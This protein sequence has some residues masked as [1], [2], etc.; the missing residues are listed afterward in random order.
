MPSLELLLRFARKFLNSSR[1]EERNAVLSFSNHFFVAYFFSRVFL[2]PSIGI[3]LLHRT[4]P[5][6]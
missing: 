2:V 5:L 1:E 3:A 4:L 6:Q